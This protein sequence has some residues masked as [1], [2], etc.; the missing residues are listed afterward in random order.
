MAVEVV[1][2]NGS[3]PS[4]RFLF[5]FRNLVS[6][7]ISEHQKVIDENNSCWWGWWKRPKEDNRI[8]VWKEL[9][10]EASE[11]NPVP[12]GLFNSGTGNVYIAHVTEV[13]QPKS[14]RAGG[15]HPRVPKGE[16]KLIPPYYRESPFSFAWMRFKEIENDA[17]D[18][19]GKY[20]F[21]EVPKLPYYTKE[22]LEQFSG[23]VIMDAAEL[24]GMDT[25]I[26]VVRPR[27][28][29]DNVQ[30][31]VAHPPSIPEPV[32]YDV[33]KAEGKTILHISDLHYAVGKN[34]KQHVWAL[35]GEG[36]GASTMVE[37]MNRAIERKNEE[38]GLVLVTGD[39]TFCGTTE[40]YA[41][42]NKGLIRLLGLLDLGKE[43]LVVVPGNHDIVW[44][45]KAS[46]N[47]TAEVQ[48]APPTATSNYRRF[49]KSLLGHEP[50]KHLSMGRRF[51][52]PSGAAV[53]I[54]ALNS[55]SLETGKNFLAGMGRVQESAFDE[56]ANTLKWGK[57]NHSL[58][59]RILAL[60]HHLT[61]TE[62]LEPAEDYY[63]GFGIAVDAV[64]IQRLAAKFGVQ[65]AVHGHKHR[66]FIWRS[67]VYELLE[68]AER[69]YRLGELSIIG[70]GSAGSCET[71]KAQNYF[72]LLD[73]SALGIDLRIF[74]S[75]HSGSFGNIKQCTARFGFSAEQQVL[76]LSDWI[77]K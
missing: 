54:A 61:L 8:S 31:I 6:D 60:H 63:K 59:F 77:V 52:F 41:E 67:S 55:S 73:I 22:I 49:Y 33:I 34:R 69:K 43:N 72:N 7:T 71:E 66:A 21:D 46:Y 58:A 37:S 64:R 51:L 38:I 36:G 35:E 19:F 47:E 76:S 62:N 24:M 14:S 18:F 3:L 57:M 9:K 56:V 12:V 32:S 5:R 28:S 29:L 68:N 13:I 27:E 39:L 50:N 23:K 16:E 25:T 75:A 45:K 26:W 65:L 70:G 11:K 20:S 53:E 44:T 17:I 42:A 4:I 10:R 74:K 15:Q 48:Q 1:M 30:K 2:D 40:E